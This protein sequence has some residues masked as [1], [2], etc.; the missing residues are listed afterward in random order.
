VRTPLELGFGAAARRSSYVYWS[1]GAVREA[2]KA[3]TM[4]GAGGGP[5]SL[6]LLAEPPQT[7][8]AS[9]AGI[10]WLR[11]SAAGRFSLEAL[12][13]TDVVAPL[14]ASPG[15]IDAVTMA[16]DA[17]FFVERPA[18]G[19]WRIGRVP[20]AGGAATFTA[21]R[22]GR[23]PSM[24]AAGRD[25]AFYQGSGF[26]VH[27]LSFDLQHEHTP[28]SGF[29]CSP[30]AVAENVYCAQL[31]GIFELAPEASP[32]RLV[33]GGPARPVTDLAVGPRHLYWI[34][35]AGPERLEVRAVELVR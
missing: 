12:R 35:D 8:V 17:L 3:G 30:V 24:L 6:T 26:E 2:P 16:G 14:Y 5:R 7:F 4:T 25:L 18:G 21:A 20:L 31:E 29:I 11:R 19:D 22:A 10:A 9:D 28:A 34:V 15:A 32:R 23:P 1:R 33:P 27:R 13:A